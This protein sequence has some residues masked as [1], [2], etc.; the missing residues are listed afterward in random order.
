MPNI[1]CPNC[2]HSFEATDALRDEIQ[3]E[4]RNKMV[5]WQNQKEQ[6]FKLKEASFKQL[7]EQKEKEAATHLET[8]KKKMAE[9]META[10][11][12]QVSGD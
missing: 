2:H 8:E 4:L 9:A 3:K 10:I 12:T 1:I 7:L 6:D 5:E 11:R